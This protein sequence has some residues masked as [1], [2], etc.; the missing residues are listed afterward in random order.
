P[1]RPLHILGA[2]AIGRGEFAD[3]LQRYRDQPP[4]GD[5]DF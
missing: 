3:Y 1:T 4:T 5:L 2:R